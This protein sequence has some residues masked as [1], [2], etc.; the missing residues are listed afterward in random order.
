MSLARP[1]QKQKRPRSDRRNEEAKELYRFNSL[2][3][4][5]GGLPPSGMTFK[6]ADMV[7]L[8]LTIRAHY[9]SINC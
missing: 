8:K 7:P 9:Y 1:W 4:R 5:T 3:E 6:Q 2:P